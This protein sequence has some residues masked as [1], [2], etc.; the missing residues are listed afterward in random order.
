MGVPVRV[1]GEGRG[2]ADSLRVVSQLLAGHENV[3]RTLT[4]EATRDLA[5]AGVLGI[6]GG[7]VGALT[8]GSRA[9]L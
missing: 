2:R 5:D 1:K 4:V 9:R 8:L 3:L 6:G 7:D